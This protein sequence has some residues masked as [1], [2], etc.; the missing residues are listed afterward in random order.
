VG[1]KPVG[2]VFFS[3]RERQ[4]F[5]DEQRR[6]IEAFA[7]YMALALETLASH[8]Q[9]KASASQEEAER[10][11]RELHDSVIQVLAGGVLAKAGAIK[12]QLRRQDYDW[13]MANLEK[14]EKAAQYVYSEVQ[15]I[16]AQLAGHRLAQA[17]LAPA[18]RDYIALLEGQD[19][20]APDRL[21]IAFE[22]DDLGA[23]ARETEHNLYRIAQEALSN[24][25]KNAH[26]SQVRVSLRRR[27]EGI[28]LTVEDDG[29]GFDVEAA[30]PHSFGL[31]GM[32]TRATA[33]GGQL[34]IESQPGMG[35][36]VT[37]VVPGE[38]GA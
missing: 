8:R 33:V 15:E 20:E 22:H 13:A 2:V 36:C 26:A 10:W 31:V 30:L 25:L 34:T 5:D 9:I 27:P 32:Q 6:V 28:V 21:A 7:N 1:D 38:E 24:A 16:R 23:L 37:A 3:F 18:V 12:G 17:G 14:L 35:T 11:D 29:C 4:A 19:G